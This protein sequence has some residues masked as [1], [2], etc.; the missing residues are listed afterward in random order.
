MVGCYAV[1]RFQY[2]KIGEHFLQH[3][4]HGTPPLAVEGCEFQTSHSQSNPGE[5][6]EMHGLGE[7][8]MHLLPGQLQASVSRTLSREPAS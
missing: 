8:Q 5:A 7:A 6:W 2:W 4:S 1:E 3:K